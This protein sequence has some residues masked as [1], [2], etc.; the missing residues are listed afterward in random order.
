[1]LLRWRSGRGGEVRWSVPFWAI[2]RR[3]FT[4][5]KES[6][7]VKITSVFADSGEKNEMETWIEHFLSHRRSSEIFH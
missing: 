2:D 6:M 4:T 3:V 7:Q 5:P 1:M